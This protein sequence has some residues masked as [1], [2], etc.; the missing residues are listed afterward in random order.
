MTKAIVVKL[1]TERSGGS[2]CVILLTI[3]VPGASF[4]QWVEARAGRVK[5]LST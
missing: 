5:Y 2:C 4:F 3:T 1:A